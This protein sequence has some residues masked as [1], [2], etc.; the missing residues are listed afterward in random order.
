MKFKGRFNSR[1]VACTSLANGISPFSSQILL[2]IGLK[3]CFIQ[4]RVSHGS[5]A[6][7]VVEHRWLGIRLVLMLRRCNAS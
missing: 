1:S 2:D 7:P 4:P 3:S 5:K 6:A